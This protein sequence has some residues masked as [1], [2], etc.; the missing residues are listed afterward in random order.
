MKKWEVFAEIK[1]LKSIGLKKSQV[2][3]KLDIDYK[4]VCKYWDM[5]HEEYADLVTTARERVKKLD[6]YESTIVSW[7]KEFSDLSAAQIDDWLRDT[8]SEYSG[9]ERTLRSYIVHLRTKYRIPKETNPRQYQEVPELPMGAQGQVDLGTM[10]VPKLQGK[11]IK[12]YCFAMV[13]SHSRHK[14]ALWSEKPFT[15]R[16]FVEAHQKAFEFYGGRPKELVYDQDR[17]LAVDENYGD[18]VYTEVFQNYIHSTKLRVRLCRA[19]DPESKGK[20][21]AVIKYLKYNF[22]RNRLYADI[23]T[24]N[25]ECVAWLKRTGNGKVHSVTKKIPAQVF[26]LEQQH[27]E[28]IPHYRFGQQIDINVTYPVRK[29]NTVLYKQ[30]RYQVPKGTYVPGKEVKISVKESNL[31]IIDNSTGE[32]IVSHAICTFKGELVRII[33]PERDTKSKVDEVYDNVLTALGSTSEA[34]LFLDNIHIEKSRYFKDQLGLIMKTCRNLNEQAI[35]VALNY[36][37]KRELWSAVYF[38]DAASYLMINNNDKKKINL[39][40]PYKHPIEKPEIRGIDEYIK[41]LGGR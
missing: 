9:S 7:L 14:F 29:N 35:A 18:I 41:A 34:R 15:S 5:S 25:D 31:N 17:I 32:L 26:A 16:S 22:A 33:H 40:F 24:F 21:E 12:L 2:E 30:N 1:R 8:Y 28:P 23:E 37:V 13:L 3:R 38:K 19:F 27:L 11:R 10:Y 4:T 20:I 39:P 6:K 36:C